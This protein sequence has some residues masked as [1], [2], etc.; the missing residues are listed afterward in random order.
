MLKMKLHFEKTLLESVLFL[1]LV[2]CPF[3]DIHVGTQPAS[4]FDAICFIS[5]LKG[6]HDPAFV[7]IHSA[8]GSLKSPVPC[9]YVLILLSR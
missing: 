2:S 1:S 6:E 9:F 4:R 3:S 5:Y 8:S 7:D